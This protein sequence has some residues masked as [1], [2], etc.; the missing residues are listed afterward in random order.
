[1]VIAHVPKPECLLPSGQSVQLNIR[2][3]G[4]VAGINLAL[5]KLD[6]TVAVPTTQAK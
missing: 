1:L 3:Q 5:I 6:F 2:G 4:I